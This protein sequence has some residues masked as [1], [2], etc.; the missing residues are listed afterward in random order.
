[1]SFPDISTATWKRKFLNGE[2]A[3]KNKNFMMIP[4]TEMK[5]TVKQ[6][7]LPDYVIKSTEFQ[8][9]K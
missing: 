3:P 9:T 7:N 4:I 8:R 6:L 2:E 5:D 1:M